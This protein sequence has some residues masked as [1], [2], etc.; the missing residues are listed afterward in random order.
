MDW[1][2][3]RPADQL[4]V[5]PL[6]SPAL[7][8]AHLEMIKAG[9]QRHPERRRRLGRAAAEHDGVPGQAFQPMRLA[10]LGGRLPARDRRLPAELGMKTMR[11]ADLFGLRLPI[12]AGQRDMDDA[13]R[14]AGTIRPP[15]PGSRSARAW[16]PLVPG[17]R[18]VGQR[19]QFGGERES[20]TRQ[21]S[22]SS[23]ELF[24]ELF[25]LAR[26]MVFNLCRAISPV[27][28]GSYL[29]EGYN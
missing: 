26:E 29:N 10:E 14:H 8:A 28:T 25:D 20:R 11:P 1:R 12:S 4:E 21:T 19:P 7:V 27:L 3:A 24:A 15:A 23:P 17:M 2:P 22:A 6:C 5:Q 13:R 16:G 9:I 18:S